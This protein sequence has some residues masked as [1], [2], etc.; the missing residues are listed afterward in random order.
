[1]S[2][3]SNTEMI[4]NTTTTTTTS[5]KAGKINQGGWIDSLSSQGFKD[6]NCFAEL[7]DNSND[8]GAKKIIID[9][10]TDCLL[11]GDNASGMSREGLFDMFEAYKPPTISLRTGKYAIGSKAG[12]CGLARKQ[13]NKIITTN[14]GKVYNTAV[15]NWEK[16]I[17]ESKYEDNIDVDPST[18]EEI[19]LFQNV[20]GTTSG[21]LFVFPKSKELTE[22][23]HS[24]FG[25]NKD[26]KDMD[27]E[28]LWSV[29]YGRTELDIHYHSQTGIDY[30]L[31]LHNPAASADIIGTISEK[32]IRFYKH[33]KNGHERFIIDCLDPETNEQA[34]YEFASTLKSC[35]QDLEKVKLCKKDYKYEG[36]L[37][38]QCYLP[39]MNI[40]LLEI[41]GASVLSVYDKDSLG[42]R[43]T[44]K[45][46]KKYNEK[47]RIIRNHIHIGVS[48]MKRKAER[49]D[50]KAN[51]YNMIQCDLIYNPP[52]VK[53]EARDKMID[54][55]QNKHQLLCV[56]PK[57]LQRLL[58]GCVEEKFNEIKEMRNNLEPSEIVITPKP[59]VK[60]AK[61]E[62]K[63]ETT[64]TEGNE[65]DDS[66]IAS[67][68]SSSSNSNVKIGGGSADNEVVDHEV[69]DGGSTITGGGGVAIGGGSGSASGGKPSK[70]IDVPSHRKG[71][72]MGSELQEKLGAL[73]T[74][75][76]VEQSYD[77][78]DYIT[79]FNILQKIEN[80]E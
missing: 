13:S 29:I 48:E 64:N 43:V 34:E 61:K 57:Q 53:D 32:S 19:Q 66:S 5:A 47:N 58:D 2:A 25:L 72:V 80:K 65:G 79:L 14:D 15:P 52:S 71:S 54:L 77:D 75:L 74:R 24:Q 78:A 35:H 44:D 56:L 46:M 41:T 9:E 3:Q 62:K 17:K 20:I 18:P 37:T 51:I 4:N 36:D 69:V 68:S 1:M 39:K 16:M 38:F 70:P 60:K 8:W 22:L 11:I 6:E 40:P 33:K 12:Q 50:W 21:T 63:D 31:N 67:T 76:N 7:F 30:K 27:P 49:A 55:Q 10:T 45:G 26:V 23:I 59:K 42:N 28:K 73:F